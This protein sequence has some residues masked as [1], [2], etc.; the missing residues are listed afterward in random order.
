MERLKTYRD[1]Y[2][3]LQTAQHEREIEIARE[4]KKSGDA[5]EKIAPI[6]GLSLA[7]SKRF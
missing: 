7:Q 2:S 3:I 4:M 1:R 6:T 5:P